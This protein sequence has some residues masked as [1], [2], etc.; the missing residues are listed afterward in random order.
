MNLHFQNL[1]ASAVAA[2]TPTWQNEIMKRVEED[3]SELARN[4]NYDFREKLL[5]AISPENALAGVIVKRMAANFP[6][7]HFIK[8]I[9]ADGKKYDAQIDLL[10]CTVSFNEIH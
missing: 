4:V 5:E 2:N 9:E 1:S 7:F 6:R 10:E 8:N 3:Y